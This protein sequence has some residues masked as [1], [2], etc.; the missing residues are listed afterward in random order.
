M[1]QFRLFRF[2][3]RNKRVKWV[4]IDPPN[5][6][7]RGKKTC[8]VSSNGT[9]SQSRRGLTV[10]APSTHPQCPGEFHLLILLL[11]LWSRFLRFLVLRTRHVLPHH[12][13]KT[14]NKKVI[15]SAHNET[16]PSKGGWTLFLARVH[17]GKPT[18]QKI[19]KYKKH[20]L[21]VYITQPSQRVNIAFAFCVYTHTTELTPSKQMKPS[22]QI[23]PSKQTLFEAEPR[24]R[25]R[26]SLP[27]HTVN[28]DL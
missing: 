24:I 21:R 27:H 3:A 25:P 22:K 14:N 13:S 17:T 6:R 20:I 9:V 19:Q 4:N 26:P 5:S 18:P 7:D 8:S 1:K 12:Y 28:L 15:A 2:W 23:K 10:A 11:C 16:Q